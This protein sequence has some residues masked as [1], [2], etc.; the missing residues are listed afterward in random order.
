M[1]R[2]YKNPNRWMI[3]YV[4]VMPEKRFDWGLLFAFLGLI[5]VAVCLVLA[6]FLL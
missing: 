5:E 3:N 4:P 6:L 1:N 2:P